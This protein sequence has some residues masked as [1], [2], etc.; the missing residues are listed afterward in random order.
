[1][2]GS[3]RRIFALSLC[4]R[5]AADQGQ[6]P[7]EIAAAEAATLDEGEKKQRYF[8]I[9]E[10]LEDPLE[11]DWSAVRGVGTLAPWTVNW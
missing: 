6:T 9:A 8:K 4:L 7:K 2:F 3:A 1:M 10:S 5:G 11:S